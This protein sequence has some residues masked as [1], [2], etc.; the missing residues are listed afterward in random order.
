[1]DDAE[2]ITGQSSQNP[3]SVKADPETERRPLTARE[4]LIEYMT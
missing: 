3:P 4:Y 2:Q 1:M